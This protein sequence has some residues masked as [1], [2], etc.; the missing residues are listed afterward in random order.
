M[1][2]D[3]GPLVAL[4]DRRDP[5]HAACHAAAAGLPSQPIVTT[6]CCFTETMYLLAASGGW[7]Y[8]AQAWNLI[9]TERLKL[10]E[11]TSA[12]I[13]RMI[14]LMDTYSNL[15]MSLADASL[16]AVA[17]TEGFSR[18]FSLDSHFRVYRLHDGSVLEVI[19]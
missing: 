3:T 6:W 14:E 5:Q 4:L 9:R 10:Y 12:Q 19:P 13:D 16:V 11:M 2:I 1:L 15:P 17:E 7:H 8:Q 18:I